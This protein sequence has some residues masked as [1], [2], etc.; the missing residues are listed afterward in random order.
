MKE[1]SGAISTAIA[2]LLKIND[3]IAVTPVP[4]KE[5]KTMS[6]SFVKCSIYA[7]TTLKG[8]KISVH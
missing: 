4:A 3:S 2:F 7:W 5:S 8:R 6:P 1:E